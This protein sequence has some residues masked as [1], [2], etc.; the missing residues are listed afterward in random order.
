MGVPQI[1][2][3]IHLSVVTRNLSLTE[4][5]L[6]LPAVHPGQSTSLAKW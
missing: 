6:K 5:L 3:K 4:E 1:L 2:L